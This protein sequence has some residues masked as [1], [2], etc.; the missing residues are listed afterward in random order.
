MSSPSSTT[1]EQSAA[2]DLALAEAALAD[3]AADGRVAPGEPL[4]KLLARSG[5]RAAIVVGGFGLL[6]LGIALIPLPGPGLLVSI[7][8]LALLAKEFVWAERLLHKARAKAAQGAGA[9]R[10]L[11]RRRTS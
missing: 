11:A 9:A 6:A 3:A 1:P 10:R 2:A 8:G 7:A 4:V 5:R